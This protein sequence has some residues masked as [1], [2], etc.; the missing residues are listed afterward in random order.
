MAGVFDT[1]GF[2]GLTHPAV[3]VRAFP[4][5][6]I[7][8]CQFGLSRIVASGRASSGFP[9]SSHPAVPGRDWAFPDRLIRPCQ[10]GL[11]RIVV[12]VRASSS[13]RA[14]RVRRIGASCLSESAGPG[15]LV[16]KRTQAEKNN[17]ITLFIITL[18]VTPIIQLSC[19]SLDYNS[20]RTFG[21]L[22]G[23]LRRRKY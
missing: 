17:K 3:P 11:S 5:R 16:K 10:L 22:I 12:S 20:S 4:D 21:S 2:P 19:C 18:M 6:R 13:Y 15:A 23:N 1:S 8:P 9:G 7:R 14:F